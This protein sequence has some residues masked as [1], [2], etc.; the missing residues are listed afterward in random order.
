MND[1]DCFVASSSQ[2]R[3]SCGNSSRSFVEQNFVFASTSNFLR[4]NLKQYHEAIQNDERRTNDVDCFVASSSQRRT[5][6]EVGQ[7]PT[8]S[9]NFLSENSDDSAIRSTCLPCRCSSFRKEA[10]SDII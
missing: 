7:S 2:R 6:D 5:E 9:T 1:V 3:I 8:S 4:K 10:G